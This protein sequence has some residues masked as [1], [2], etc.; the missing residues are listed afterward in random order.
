MTE[1]QCPRCGREALGG[2]GVWSIKKPYCSACG[3]NVE[4]A[5]SLAG[6][7]Q[8]LLAVFFVAIVVFFVGLA[9]TP[10]GAS[11]KHPGSVLACALILAIMAAISWHRS[12]S[13]KQAQA[14]VATSIATSSSVPGVSQTQRPFPMSDCE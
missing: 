1:I 13:Q 6:K 7:N 11:Q 3:S 9:F 2:G 10:G 14:T 12:K 4:R 5:N 8:K